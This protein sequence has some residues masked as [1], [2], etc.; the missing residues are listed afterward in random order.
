MELF[1]RLCGFDGRALE[2]LNEADQRY[3]GVSSGL[4]LAGTLLCGLSAFYLFYSCTDSFLPA[5]LAAGLVFSILYSL[6]VVLISGAAF[7]IFK[8]DNREVIDKPRWTRMSIF[9]LISLAF[10]QPVMVLLLESSPLSQRIDAKLRQKSAVA[11]QT[12]QTAFESL[13]SKREREIAVMSELY[14]RLLAD[15]YKDMESVDQI[16]PPTKN[17]GRKALVIGNQ[18]YAYRPL[19]NPK[20]DASDM[21]A[22]LRK[23][24]FEV[25]VLIDADR[26]R[27]QR[28]LD[29]YVE[30][31][32][33]KDIS[34]F[35]FSGHGFQEN[36]GNYLLPIG[37][38]TEKASEAIGLSVTLEKISRR[39]PL[40]SVA[41][42]DACRDFPFGTIR[43]GGLKEM[44][45]AANTYL[46][47]AA[48]PGQRAAEG[49]PGANGLFS[50]A[51]I[52]NISRNIDIDRVFRAVRDE[53]FRQSG[54]AQL[55][56]AIS[57]LREDFILAAPR[58]MKTDEVP[59]DQPANKASDKS[60]ISLARAPFT[61]YRG[62]SVNPEQQDD[63]PNIQYCGISGDPD[64]DAGVRDQML[65]CVGKK[66]LRAQ[67]DLVKL[68]DDVREYEAEFSKGEDVTIQKATRFMKAYLM[69]WSGA[70]FI[71][72]TIAFS[73]LLLLILAS[74]HIMREAFPSAFIRYERERQALERRFVE[75]KYRE[76]RQDW[77]AALDR[78][79]KD[80]LAK[81]P[82]AEPIDV[83]RFDATAE[84]DYHRWQ[85]NDHTPE[86]LPG[87]NALLQALKSK[88]GP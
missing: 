39:N 52:R 2:R 17:S 24:G 54:G 45:V 3:L 13:Q 5:V 65:L 47:M 62:L 43:R 29:T 40:I 15:K 7:P 61:K 11:H 78:F 85:V 41:I 68:R 53:V 84:Q 74:G 19:D 27:F 76:R 82:N 4:S 59:P 14:D 12:M 50:G 87:L 33:S 66:I 26:M 25:T 80:F 67:D 28:G 71:A 37:M 70:V 64:E 75:R 57:T 55:P 49:A 31:L 20:K 48:G 18:S 23:M 30:S 10:T 36:N 69:L 72:G 86:K 6:L 51:V 77:E 63:V 34:L 58:K 79:N 81:I 21:A 56:S 1:N 60:Q 32:R 88:K 46:A 42:I 38:K 16:L 73:I 35:Y 44:S 83:A 9:L 22:E 8:K